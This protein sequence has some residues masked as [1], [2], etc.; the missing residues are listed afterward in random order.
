MLAV[1]VEIPNS[2]GNE[3]CMIGL[4]HVPHPVKPKRMHYDDLYSVSQTEP[5]PLPQGGG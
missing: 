1:L 2:K 4:L 5:P 3:F